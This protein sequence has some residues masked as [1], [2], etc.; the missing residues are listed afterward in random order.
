MTTSTFWTSF[1]FFL[2]YFRY[3]WNTL[4]GL[5]SRLWAEEED[6]HL[7]VCHFYGMSRTDNNQ[8]FQKSTFPFMAYHLANGIIEIGRLKINN[9]AKNFR[10]Q[11]RL[12]PSLLE[13]KLNKKYFELLEVK[14]LTIFAQIKVFQ[15]VFMPQSPWL[16]TVIYFIVAVVS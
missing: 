4:F 1:F 5:S 12:N 6:F 7:S 16:K 11:N 8:P 9:V 13:S 14:H 2:K 10:F 3:C 15:T